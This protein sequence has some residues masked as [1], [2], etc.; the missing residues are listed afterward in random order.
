MASLQQGDFKFARLK[1]IITNITSVA[2]I[3]QARVSVRGCQWCK[4]VVSVPAV[5][6]LC[7]GG[8]R[9]ST[10]RAQVSLAD[11]RHYAA[12][13]DQTKHGCS[14]EGSALDLQSIT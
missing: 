4:E 5:P 9:S 1:H 10:L 8:E 12:H 13:D 3:D 2:T 14:R 11:D 7:A 6:D